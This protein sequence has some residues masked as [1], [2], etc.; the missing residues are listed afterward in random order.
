MRGRNIKF[1]IAKQIG[2]NS[3]SNFLLIKGQYFKLIFNMTV[4]KDIPKFKEIH[5]ECPKA[6]KQNPGRK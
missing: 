6:F 5:K 3:Q 2:Q 1:W 4:S